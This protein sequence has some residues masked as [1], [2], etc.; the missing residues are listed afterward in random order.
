MVSLRNFPLRRWCCTALVVLYSIGRF[1][2]QRC[3]CIALVI[4]YSTVVL[5]PRRLHLRRMDSDPASAATIKIED[6]STQ[7]RRSSLQQCRPDWVTLHS[8][9]QLLPTSLSVKS[10]CPSQYEAETLCVSSRMMEQALWANRL[11]T[12]LSLI[13]RPPDRFWF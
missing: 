8:I 1:V 10:M 11:I 3:S 12:D 2:Q 4:L 7:D 9:A 13:H 6:D 5:L